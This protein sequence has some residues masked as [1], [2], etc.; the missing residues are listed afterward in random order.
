MGIEWNEIEAR[1]GSRETEAERHFS[2]QGPRK[3][4]LDYSAVLKE[5]MRHTTTSVR[6]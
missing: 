3:R 1:V 4:T 6:R 5:L 2:V